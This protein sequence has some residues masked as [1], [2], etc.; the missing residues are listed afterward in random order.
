MET[1][2]QIDIDTLNN[3][4]RLNTYCETEVSFFKSRKSVKKAIKK[5][6]ILLNDKVEHGGTWLKSGDKITIV[7]LELTPPKPYHLKLEVIFEDDYLAIINKPAGL[8]VSGNQFKTLQNALPGNL[9]KSSAEDKLAWPLPVHRLDSQTSGLVIVAKTK[10]TRIELGNLFE[11][12]K[13]SK[14]YHAIVMGKSDEKGV[15]NLPVDGKTA[16]TK[17]DRL[18]FVRSLQNEWISL[19][20]LYPKTG[21]THQLRIHLSEIGTPILGDKL[22]SNKTL[23]HKGLFLMASGLEFTH[24]NTKQVLKFEVLL[25]PKFEKRLQNEEKRWEKFNSV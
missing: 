13:I 19:L 5:G 20:K 18:K 7:D 25:S 10:T 12:Q 23:K 4:I 6:E 14:I 8:Q 1:I 3:P 21:R 22:Y 11:L 2:L 24:P 16:Y 9:S 15:I 17:F